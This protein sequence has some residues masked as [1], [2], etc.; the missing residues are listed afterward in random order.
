MRYRISKISVRNVADLTGQ[1]IRTVRRHVSQG[2]LSFGPYTNDKAAL[3][4]Y[5]VARMLERR[6]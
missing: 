4:R 6:A 5:M 1:S 2:R 3:V